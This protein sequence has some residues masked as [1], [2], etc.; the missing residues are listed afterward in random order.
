MHVSCHPALVLRLHKAKLWYFS[1]SLTCKPCFS[2][3]PRPLRIDVAAR[4][5][6]IVAPAC[7][8]CC[9]IYQNSSNGLCAMGSIFI[10]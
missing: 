8:L 10:L 1:S 4:F 5:P 7:Y 6:P 3:R 9:G 2:S